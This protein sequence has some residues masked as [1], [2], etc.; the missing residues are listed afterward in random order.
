MTTINVK[1]KQNSN[2]SLSRQTKNTVN[3]QNS[4]KRCMPGDKGGKS[5][6]A[7]RIVSGFASNGCITNK[8]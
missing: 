8:K 3:N 7:I 2:R 1:Q 4:Q 5:Q 6:I